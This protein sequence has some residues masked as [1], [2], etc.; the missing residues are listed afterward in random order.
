MPEED[1]KTKSS[2]VESQLKG[3][4]EK[5]GLNDKGSYLSKDIV[6]EWTINPK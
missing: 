2:D 6:S 1:K 4:E 3:M 5:Y